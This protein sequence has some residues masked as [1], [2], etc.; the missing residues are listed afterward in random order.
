M[1]P[2]FFDFNSNFNPLKNG[3]T[4]VLWDHEVPEKSR[5]LKWFLINS[6]TQTPSYKVDISES[7]V[8]DPQK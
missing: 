3:K 6:K 4:K 1:I 5:F 7:K 8:Y 2:R